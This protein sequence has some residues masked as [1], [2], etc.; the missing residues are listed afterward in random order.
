MIVASAKA[1]LTHARPPVF[2]VPASAPDSELGSALIS[3]AD[4]STILDVWP[5]KDLAEHW[6]REVLA[7][8]GIKDWSTLERG[9]KLVGVER[10]EQAWTFTPM[11]R[12]RGGGWVRWRT[13]DDLPVTRR[14]FISRGSS[15]D[16]LGA[17]LKEALAGPTPT[18]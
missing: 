18:D 6:K 3:A 8:V 4:A 9:A 14:T 16:V 7:E 15:V 17:A 12:R 10:G 2:I 1:N 13:D 5:S 11:R